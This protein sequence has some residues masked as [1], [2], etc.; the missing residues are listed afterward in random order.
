M[1]FDELT[2]ELVGLTD[3]MKADNARPDNAVFFGMIAEAHNNEIP[4]TCMSG[5]FVCSSHPQ[6]YEMIRLVLDSGDKGAE[7]FIVQAVLDHLVE[8]GE[9][10]VQEIPE[11]VIKPKSNKYLD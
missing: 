8:N 4:D 11:M 9:A 10:E 6:I 1:N 7:R 5:H 3:K 2:Q